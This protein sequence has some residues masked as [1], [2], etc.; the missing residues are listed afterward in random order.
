MTAI[1]VPQ[2]SDA[3]ASQSR[4]ACDSISDVLLRAAQEVRLLSQDAANLDTEI[5]ELVAQSVFPAQQ[6]LQA[7]DMLRQRLE[8]LEQFLSELVK[9]LEGDGRCSPLRATKNLTL[10]AQAMRLRGDDAGSERPHEAE[11]ELWEG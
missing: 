10:Q 3:G 4:D 5:S 8:G 11:P 7:A 9:T 6:G 2:P 1:S